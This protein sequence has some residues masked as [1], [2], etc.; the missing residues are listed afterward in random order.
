MPLPT[1]KDL[2]QKCSNEGHSHTWGRDLTHNLRPVC[3][4]LCVCVSER[5]GADLQIKAIYGST[6]PP[7]PNTSLYS[8]VAHQVRS[9]HMCV[10]SS[11]MKGL[12]CRHVEVPCRFAEGISRQRVQKKALIFWFFFFFLIQSNV[13]ST[14]I[15]G[16]RISLLKS[17]LV[18]KDR[19]PF[20]GKVAQNKT[21]RVLLLHR[22][23]LYSFLSEQRTARLHNVKEFTGCL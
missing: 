20:L 17:S 21:T 23:K 15:D 8:R 6:W 14:L 19:S 22:D 9:C 4:C 3:V 2:K 1:E 10:L 18:G 12:S 5:L 11:H 13:R 7:S 16:I